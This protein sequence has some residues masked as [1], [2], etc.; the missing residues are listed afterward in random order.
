MI[1]SV[2]QEQKGVTIILSPRNMF[3]FHS[4]GFFSGNPGF[5]WR[6]FEFLWPY[7]AGARG[8]HSLKFSCKQCEVTEESTHHIF[9]K[10]VYKPS[11]GGAYL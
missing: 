10:S 7:M 3:F 6:C 11:G 8:L 9:I 2:S 5:Y 1:L 4:L